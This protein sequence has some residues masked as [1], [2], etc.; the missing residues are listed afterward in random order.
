MSYIHVFVLLCLVLYGVGIDRESFDESFL[1]VIFVSCMFIFSN[2]WVHETCD[3]FLCYLIVMF[4][5][6][7]HTD[8]RSYHMVV[9]HI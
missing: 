3:I 2:L 5:S 1:I 8:W 7:E 9:K 6:W 4:V